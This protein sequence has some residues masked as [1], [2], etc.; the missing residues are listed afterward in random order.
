[1]SVWRFMAGARWHLIVLA[2][3]LVLAQ[4]IALVH[5]VA[6]APLPRGSAQLLQAGLPEH[7]Q[8]SFAEHL[9]G[10]HHDQDGNSICH[11]FDQSYQPDTLCGV[12]TV[13]LPTP[14]AANLL[15]AIA[16]LNVA[17]WLVAFHA[18]G[19]PSLR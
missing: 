12:H 7:S 10:D 6:H 11:L 5:G 13:A 4:G 18:R 15:V 1:M 9:F 16:G 2:L 8:E 17:R 19:P 3:A 14:F